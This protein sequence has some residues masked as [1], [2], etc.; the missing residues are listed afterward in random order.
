LETP[1]L[2][3][4]LLRQEVELHSSPA[5]I[6]VNL[7]ITNTINEQESIQDEMTHANDLEIFSNITELNPTFL[8]QRSVAHGRS[9]ETMII[10]DWRMIE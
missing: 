2:N 10:L 7:P 8:R 9:T 4:D 6:L 1:E 3:P 5:S